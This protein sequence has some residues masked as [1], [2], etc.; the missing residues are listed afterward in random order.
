MFNFFKKTKEKAEVAI[1]ETKEKVG[2]LAESA[3]KFIS[4][5]NNQLKT[6]SIVVL[7]VGASMIVSNLVNIGTN[8]YIAKHI[9][10]N[11]IVINNYMSKP[12]IGRYRCESNGGIF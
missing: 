8:I 3:D 4:D 10:S 6:I 2:K 12:D 1:V 5:G 9:K 11:N 7:A